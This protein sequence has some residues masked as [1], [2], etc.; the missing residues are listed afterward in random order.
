MDR[1]DLEMIQ[2]M[3]ERILQDAPLDVIDAA[4]ADDDQTQALW[5]SL[6]ENGY[7]R[8]C[9][10]ETQGGAEASLADALPLLTLA[11][12]FALP[13]PLGETIIAGA[14]LSAAGMAMPEGPI[15]VLT[16]TGQLPFAGICRQAVRLDADKVELLAIPEAAIT[17]IAQAEDRLGEVDLS[18]C[19]VLDEA[20]APTAY[21]ATSWRAIGAAA[22]AAYM[23]G[24]M[25]AILDLTLHYTQD[26]EQ[27]GRP[28]AK[29]QAIQ[30]HLSDIAG[31][32][33]A[34]SAAV[35]LMADA[36]ATDPVF[37]EGCQGD[38]AVAKIRCGEAATRVAAASHQAHGAMGFTREYVL[39]RYTRRLWQWQ[40][41]YGSASEWAIH[42]G[43]TIAASPPTGLWPHVSR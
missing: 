2:D 35:D 18:L 39:G 11:G 12:R 17:E 7:T 36:M 15:G 33:A 29:F 25:Q 14:V 42:L 8:L 16:G 43:R 38:I 24:A 5:G 4:D 20:R 37:G 21:N 1:Y 41:E 23:A 34:C 32:T 31:E 30:H 6:E 27:F 9:C 40:D 28:L 26:R 3:L 19:E 10:A 13:L 22:R